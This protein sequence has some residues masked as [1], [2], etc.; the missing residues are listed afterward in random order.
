MEISDNTFNTSIFFD[1]NELGFKQI[2]PQYLMKIEPKF[3]DNTYVLNANSHGLL[4][5]NYTHPTL[6]ILLIM[7]NI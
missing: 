7:V 1:T 3:H 6:I 5:S 2:T 4:A